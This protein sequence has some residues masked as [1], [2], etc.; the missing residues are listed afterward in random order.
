MMKQV[1]VIEVLKT[2][3]HLLWNKM[4]ENENETK[5]IRQNGNVLIIS[6]VD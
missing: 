6:E 4:E 5:N 3:R 1:I 2:C